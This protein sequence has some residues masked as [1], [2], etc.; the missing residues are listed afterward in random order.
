MH[1]MIIWRGLNNEV[2]DIYPGHNTFSLSA[3]RLVPAKENHFL[4]GCDPNA[5]FHDFPASPTRLQLHT[6]QVRLASCLP[7]VSGYGL[8]KMTKRD[9]VT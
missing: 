1:Y 9:E 4:I 7:G 2:E 8:D 3:S 6:L 5:R